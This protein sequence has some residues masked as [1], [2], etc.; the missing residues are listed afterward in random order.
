VLDQAT[1]ST[2]LAAIDAAYA[3]M[4]GMNRGER[5]AIVELCQD[6]CPDEPIDVQ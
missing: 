4:V 5:I 1:A 3:D 6:A 2:I